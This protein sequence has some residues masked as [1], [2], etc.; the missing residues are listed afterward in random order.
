[1]RNEATADLPELPLD[2][3][4]VH[5]LLLCACDNAA[6]AM[7]ENQ[8][9]KVIVFEAGIAPA[10]IDLRIRDNGRGMSPETLDRLRTTPG[11]TDR[12]A[13]SGIGMQIIR[14]VCAEH[15]AELA[16]ES[17]EGRGTTLIVRFPRY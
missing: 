12:R 10:I 1:M 13:G 5:L 14:K 17:S 2:A 8:S 3:P 11:F 15:A 4:S 7:S 9:E 6:E 16:I